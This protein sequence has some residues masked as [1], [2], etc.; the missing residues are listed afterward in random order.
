MK[1]IKEQLIKFL[2]TKAV[3][4]ALKKLLGSAAAG[5]IA[6]FLVTYIVEHLFTEVAIPVINYMYRKGMLI[7]DKADGKLKVKKYERAKEEGD[8]DTYLSTI[9]R[10]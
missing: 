6:G 1:L 7:Y 9:G 5:G 8:L 4:A 3:K 10:V 2:K